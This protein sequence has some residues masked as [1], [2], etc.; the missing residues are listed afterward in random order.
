MNACVQLN[1]V[2]GSSLRC[3]YN[4]FFYSSI[5]LF[6]QRSVHGLMI[7]RLSKMCSIRFRRQFHSRLTM[8]FLIFAA[9]LH[10]ARLIH[11][12]PHR[13]AH[14]RL[15]LSQRQSSWNAKVRSI[16]CVFVFV[17]LFVDVDVRVHGEKMEIEIARS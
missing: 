1:S 10:S 13:L 12:R 2:H 4:C 11:R 9:I 16:L 3:L 15:S 5:Q 8:N 7:H 6:F 17:H 14:S